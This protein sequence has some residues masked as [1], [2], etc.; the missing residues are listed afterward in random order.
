[1]KKLILIAALP[2]LAACGS[3]NTSAP[4]SH[5]NTAPAA[6]IAT[7]PQT[8]PAPIKTSGSRT[9]T[10][11]GVLKALPTVRPVA[12]ATRTPIP[13]S[14][15]TAVIFGKITDAKTHTPIAGAIISEGASKQVVKSGP[16]GGYKISFPG[17]ATAPITVRAQGYLGTLAVGHVGTHVKYR[18]NVSLR[19]AGKNIANAP[20]P[21]TFFSHP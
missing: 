14:A 5:K 17:N 20:P 3:S 11:K 7:V 19:R 9:K 1:M 16:F 6:H 10:G 2:L 15:Y 8:S 4:K 12:Q 13:L 18:L 21:P